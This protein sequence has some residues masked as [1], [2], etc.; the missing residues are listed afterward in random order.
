MAAVGVPFHAKAGNMAH[1]PSRSQGSSSSNSTPLHADAA[2][3]AFDLSDFIMFDQAE[4][5]PSSFGPEPPVVP[6]MVDGG[7][8]NDQNSNLSNITINSGDM[9]V[10]AR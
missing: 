6:P 9:T 5:A 10:N 7:R 8:S 3:P 2:A 4:F 1:F